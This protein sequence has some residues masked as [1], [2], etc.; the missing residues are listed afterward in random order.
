MR[1]HILNS[2]LVA[3]LVAVICLLGVTAYAAVKED[4]P[5]T[6]CLRAGKGVRQPAA[7]CAICSPA[8]CESLATGS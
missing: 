3:A 4:L 1:Q 6:S 8:P 7:T 2:W 5:R